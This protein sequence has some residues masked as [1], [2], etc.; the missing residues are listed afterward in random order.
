MR[1]YFYNESGAAS[2]VLNY[3]DFPSPIPKPGEVR[4]KLAVSGIN[5]TD[6]KRRQTGRELGKFETIIPN[7][8]GAG[9][10][11]TV[12]NKVAP[13]R[14][15]QRVWLF[16]A[17]A[18]RPFGTAAEFCVVPDAYAIPLPDEVSFAEGACLGVPAVTAHRGLF[19]SGKITGLTILISG[20]TGRVGR[21]TLQMAKTAG[22]LVISTA[23]SVEK[24]VEMKE[25][26]ADYVFNYK[27]D[28][29]ESAVLE[30]TNGKGVDR[31]VDVE[32][33]S[34]IELAPKLIKSNGHLTAYGSDAIPT[35]K[36]PFYDFMFKNITIQAFSI[37]GMPEKAKFTAFKYINQMLE[38]GSLHHRID[39]H[40]SFDEMI[41]AHENLERNNLSG[42]CLVSI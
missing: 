2:A 17:Q 1:A 6:C 26:G 28:N 22:A 33:G 31:M 25:L 9:V 42:S 19:G 32:F 13:T 38:T 36:M 11:E 14:V 41:I 12:G 30:I 35:P 4:V 20:G 29:I 24:C 21:Y 5:P 16:G 7:N 27:T 39:S 10:I 3:G 37:F 34:N 18:N 40:Y 15:G 8:D 23:G